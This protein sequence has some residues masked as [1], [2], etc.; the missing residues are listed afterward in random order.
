MSCLKRKENDEV[1]EATA[2][3]EEEL[4]QHK[5]K[6][7]E[8][9]SGCTDH[10]GIVTEIQSGKKRRHSDSRKVHL[11]GGGFVGSL[12]LSETS[13]DSSAEESENR[14]LDK[15]RKIASKTETADHKKSYSSSSDED[16]ELG[17]MILV[18]AKPV[19]KGRKQKSRSKGGRKKRRS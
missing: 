19:F 4:S 1:S 12:H 17:N 11:F 7:G 9:A 6:K 16:E 5:E 2:A 13:N 14:D 3:M 10:Q 15:R 18:T 8:S